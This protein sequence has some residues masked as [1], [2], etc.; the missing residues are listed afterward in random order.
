MLIS[1]RGAPPRADARS[2]HIPTQSFVATSLPGGDEGS[3]QHAQSPGITSGEG[4]DGWGLA[5]RTD[6]AADFGTVIP[7]KAGIHP[8]LAK[9]AAAVMVEASGWIPACAGTTRVVG[10]GMKRYPTTLSVFERSGCRFA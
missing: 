1:A 2:L 9:R 4:R 7:A 8:E 5:S 6:Q 3:L 10:L